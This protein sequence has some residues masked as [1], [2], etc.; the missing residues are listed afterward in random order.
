M[1]VSFG[2]KN[3]W[4]NRVD[5]LADDVAGRFHIVFGRKLP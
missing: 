5:F 1:R 2:I 4:Q 3:V